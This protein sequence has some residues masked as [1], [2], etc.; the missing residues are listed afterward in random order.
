MTVSRSPLCV[1]PL[2]IVLGSAVLAGCEN[3][4]EAA[5]PNQLLGTWVTDHPEYFD[6]GFAISENTIVFYTGPR[7]A[8]FTAHPIIETLAEDRGSATIYRLRYR[9]SDGTALTFSLRLDPDE[10]GI[11]RLPD[12]PLITWRQGERRGS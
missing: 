7:L 6:R 10:E 11:A 5:A 12:Q 1:I 4:L 3:D 9:G 2:V 8:D